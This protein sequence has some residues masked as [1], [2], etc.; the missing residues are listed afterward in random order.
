MLR[1]KS[2]NYIYALSCLRSFDWLSYCAYNN[3]YEHCFWHH[4]RFRQ[5]QPNHTFQCWLLSRYLRYLILHTNLS[6]KR[7]GCTARRQCSVKDKPVVYKCKEHCQTDQ[8]VGHKSMPDLHGL[9][10]TR[11]TV[12]R[13]DAKQPPFRTVCSRLWLALANPTQGSQRM[14][15]CQTAGKPTYAVTGSDFYAP[16]AVK[17]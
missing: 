5:H 4:K 14:L 10:L 17:E 16:Y 2:T 6:H 7:P 8:N 1:V 3:G 15:G 13:T 9:Q 12:M 11:R